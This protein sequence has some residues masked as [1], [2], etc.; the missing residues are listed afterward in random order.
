MTNRFF[1][2]LAFSFIL[3]T[4]ACSPAARIGKIVKKDV[5]TDS[6]LCN[7]HVGIS[8]YD[9]EKKEFLYNYQGEKYF[10][11][12][13][14]TKLFTTYAG[15]KFLGDSITGIKYAENDTAV[16]IIP[17]GDPGF[18]HPDFTRQPVLDF[19]SRQTKPVYIDDSHWES[20]PLGIGWDWDDY[21]YAYS[22]ERSPFPAYG[23]LIK[24]IQ[25][26]E[27]SIDPFTGDTVIEKNVSTRPQ[28]SW[29]VNF[30]T[31]DASR[32]RVN[33]DRDKNVYFI[34]LGGNQDTEINV[35]Y[36]TNGVEGLIEILAEEYNI[37][38]HKGKLPAG[39]PLTELH[40]WHIDS[41]LKPFMHRSDNL[42]GEQ[43]MLMI[44]EQVFGKMN[45]RLAI[46]T[47]LKSSLSGIPHLPRWNDGS[48]LSGSNLFT[49]HSIIFLLDKMQSEFGMDRLKGIIA[50]GGEGTI[51]NF[52]HD[53]KGAI[54]AKTG[55][56]S[57]VVT[58]S[59]YL[60]TRKNKLLYF[61]VLVNNHR[62]NATA[63]RRTV[64]SFLQ[65]VYHSN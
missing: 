50:T 51:R 32:F 36:V 2:L 48:G 5:L 43:I 54:Y 21:N 65:Q 60:Y 29:D 28:I 30:N 40:T 8:I 37:I 22:P 3:L 33:R 11:P 25:Q 27:K 1:Q 26:I 6:S 58:L 55:T 39:L 34:S 20:S 47:V 19:L 63:I 61:S 64:E 7:A 46:D 15:L 13:S 35:P 52:Y 17:T 42:Y 18:L 9:S 24:W 14:N 49:P 45:E 16:F 44:S 57:G 12:A 62:G 38:L 56:L 53:Q 23:N 10:V 4:I 59:G 41:L 31:S